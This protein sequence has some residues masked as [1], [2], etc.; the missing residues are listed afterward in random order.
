MPRT[1]TKNLLAA[2]VFVGFAVYCASLV[3]TTG[4]AWVMAILLLTVYLFA[5]E[6]L[7]VDVA[8]ILIM[9]LLGLTNLFAPWMGLTE[10]LVSS[11]NLFDGFASNAVISIIAVM[12][13]GA[14]LDKTGIMRRVAAFILR[15]GGRR[16]QTLIPI[17]S[18]TVGIISSFMQ[19]VGAA[20][21][22]IPVVSRVSNRSGIAMSRLLMPMGFCAILG[23]TVTMI[24]SSPLILLNDL[25]KVSNENLPPEQQLHTWELFDVTP[26]GLIL[27][28]TGILYFILA[29]RYVLP[30][31]KPREKNKETTLDYLKRNYDLNLSLAE[32]EVTPDS[33]LLNRKLLEVETQY[34]VRIIAIKDGTQIRAGVDSLDRDIEFKQGQI[35][36][37]VGLPEREDAFVERT[38]LLEHQG[39]P[40]FGD[41]LSDKRSG[42]AE[43]VIPTA[44][45]IIDKSAIDVWMRKR[46]GISLMGILRNGEVLYAED[47]GV[48]E[49]RAIPFQAGD[50]LLVYTTWESLERLEEDRDFIIV[51]T[52]YPRR[53]KTRPHKL[54][55]ALTFFAIALSL[56]LFT[57][58]QLSTALLTGAV[59][60]II[61]RVISMEEAYNAVSWKTVFLLASLIP[62]GYAVEFTGTAKWI[63]DGVLNVVGDLP[64]WAIQTAV[65]LLATLFSLVMSNVGATVLLVPLVVNIAI[66]VD[67]NP[68]VMALIAAI[69]TSNS[70]LIP[71]HQVNALIMGPAGY[72]V[73][74][75]LRAGGVMTFLFVVVLIV[76]VNML[77]YQ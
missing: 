71:T 44:S 12:I 31:V 32:V 25:I 56:I 46:Y 49:I 6:I 16:E 52:E 35:L 74:D 72:R 22:F 51:T 27:V 10:G 8:A 24:G 28:I 66:G 33:P 63:A 42:M 69:A 15:I 60:M 50:M 3:P 67:A 57:D 18:G 5:F 55:W 23:G 38:G 29:G 76:A 2:L 54:G 30:A 62:L 48:D 4:M 1:L 7:E 47:S 14:G 68:S 53:E 19:N 65:A 43:L 34:N 17:I 75:F 20:A 41:L 37:V 21:L 58:L 59:G 64:I 13:I 70:F 26:I 11:E 45:S 61:T 40:V 9:V 77:G 73:A 36:G 39:T